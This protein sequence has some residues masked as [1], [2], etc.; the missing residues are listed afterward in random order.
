MNCQQIILQVF[1]GLFVSD[2][3]GSQPIKNWNIWNSN[4]LLTLF[5]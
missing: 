4:N 2:T 5:D 3:T 1:F